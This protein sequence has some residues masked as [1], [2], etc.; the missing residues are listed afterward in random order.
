MTLMRAKIEVNVPRKRKGNC[1]QRDKGLNKFY[2]TVLQVSCNNFIGYYYYCRWALT[3][4]VSLTAFAV[5]HPTFIQFQAVLRHVNFDIVKCV[6]IAS[7]GF[8]KVIMYR[9][10][11]KV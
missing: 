10:C 11:Q 9:I 3:R 6:L 7:P 8:V 4:L 2:E 5:V 1:T